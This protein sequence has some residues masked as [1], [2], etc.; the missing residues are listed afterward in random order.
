MA[1]A[2]PGSVPPTAGEHRP[3]GEQNGA[4]A[5]DRVIEHRWWGLIAWT[6]GL[7]MGAGAL[8]DNSFLTHLATGRLFRE[9]GAP[10]H[11]V[12][13]F[14]SGGKALVVQSW[15]ASWTYATL[16]HLGGATAIRMFVALVTGALLATVW[17]LSRPADALVARLGLTAGA[18]MMGLL[19][20]NERPQLLAFLA[21]ALAALVLGERRSPW[22]LVPIFVVWVNVHGSFPLG[23]LYVGAAT[24]LWLV[25]RRADGRRRPDAVELRRAAQFGVAVVLGVG[26]GA[27]LSPYGMEMLSFPVRLLRRSSSL[28]LISEWRPLSLD[29]AN[30]VVFLVEAVAIAALLAMRRSWLRLAVAAVF[31]GLTLMAIRN[32]AI[33]ALVLVPLAAPSLAGLGTPDALGPAPRRRLLQLGAAAA[34][35]VGVVVMVTPD[36]DLSSYP[37]AAVDWLEAQGYVGRPHGEDLAVLSHDYS[38]NYLEWRF[39]TRANPWFDDRAELHSFATVRDYVLLLSNIGDP[40][41][42]LA[43]HPHD[44]VMWAADTGLARHLAHDDAYRIVYRDAGTV[45]ACR[46]A[47][48]RC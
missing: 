16:E 11:D 44:L 5:A 25:E 45:I 28:I 14:A 18:A 35:V 8:S 6:T 41:T 27:A 17:R 34:L 21:L 26:L 33:A 2:I 46:V 7:V 32:G 37:V 47:S 43:R 15:L 4:R 1:L 36:Y 20:W 40:D 24:G 10:H 19:W 23:V 13:T 39:G 42:I 38:G 48:H 9:S 30:N 3:A 22:W 29:N 12:F 31:V